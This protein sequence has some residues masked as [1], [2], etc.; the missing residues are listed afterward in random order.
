M[1]APTVMQTS[2]LRV[3]GPRDEQSCA[4]CRNWVGRTLP[5]EMQTTFATY[6][7]AEDHACRCKLEPAELKVDPEDP[8]CAWG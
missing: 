7:R 6:H 2:W 8:G 1:A 5:M 3:S 4:W